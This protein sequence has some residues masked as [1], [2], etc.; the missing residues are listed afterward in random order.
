MNTKKEKT[1]IETAI[2][3]DGSALNGLYIISNHKLYNGFWGKNGYNSMTI[4]GYN[5]DKVFHFGDYLR[6]VFQCF[7]EISFS[8]DVPN[9]YDC[10]R[11]CFRDAVV[12][13]KEQ[14]SAFLIA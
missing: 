7:K 1:L 12:V 6:D 13:D 3:Y 4:L 11:L 9:E 10:I 5:K 14:L 8:I 2:E